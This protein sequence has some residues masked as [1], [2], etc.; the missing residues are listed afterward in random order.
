MW[1]TSD[2]NW[3][4]YRTRAIGNTFIISTKIKQPVSGV[5][6]PQGSLGSKI[7]RILS[8]PTPEI[9][10][11]EEDRLTLPNSWNKDWFHFTNILLKD[12]PRPFLGYS[13]MT[14]N[15]AEVH[16]FN[17]VKISNRVFKIVSDGPFRIGTW[18]CDDF[19]GTIVQWKLWRNIGFVFEDRPYS[20]IIP[21]ERVQYSTVGEEYDFYIKRKGFRD[22]IYCDPHVSDRQRWREWHPNND[23]YHIFSGATGLGD[24]LGSTHAEY[25]C[26]YKLLG[27]RVSS[28]E[29]YDDYYLTHL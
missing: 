22:T 16:C 17:S 6:H 12:N 24:Y 3:E 9:I 5:Q 28:M 29:S 18:D 27:N 2:H 20:F 8:K 7:K 11:P 4:K 1:R 10:K 21:R 25:L 14:N 19:N 15:W 23:Y 26:V 13:R